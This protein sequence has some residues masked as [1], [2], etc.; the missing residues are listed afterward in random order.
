[1]KIEEKH[2]NLLNLIS[3]EDLTEDVEIA[4]VVYRIASLRNEDHTWITKDI[5]TDDSALVIVKKRK[6]RLVAASIIAVGEVGKDLVY[7]QNLFDISESEYLPFV[8]KSDKLLNE[9]LNNLMLE[10]VQLMKEKTVNILYN[11]VVAL[12]NKVEEAIVDSTPFLKAQDD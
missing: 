8:R 5:N 11:K 10:V 6:D 3:G 9:L 2:K 7:K 1:M 12:N 4:G